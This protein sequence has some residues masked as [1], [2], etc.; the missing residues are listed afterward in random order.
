MP[1]RKNYDK[2]AVARLFADQ[3]GLATRS[4]L[5]GLGVP[6]STI[7]H[8]ERPGGPWRRVLRGVCATHDHA[9][10]R[11]AAGAVRAALLYAGPGSVATGFA[12]L[13]AHG[14]TAATPPIGPAAAAL[15]AAAPA[16]PGS[17]AAAAAA[18]PVPTTITIPFP[19]TAA[20]SRIPDPTAPTT[21]KVLIPS[22]RRRSSTGYVLTSRTRRMPEPVGIEGCRIAPVARAAVDACLDTRDTELIRRIVTELVHTGLCS[23]TDLRVE[24]DANQTR[25]SARMRAVLVEFADGIRTG[26]EAQCRRRLARVAAPPALWNRRVVERSTG[27]VAPLPV[28][29]WPRHGVALDLDPAPAG[30]ESAAVRRRWISGVLRMTVAQVTA[31]EVRDRWDEVWAELRT[32]LSRPPTYQLPAGYAFA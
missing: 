6:P 5:I 11:T 30:H 15:A 21:V 29:V 27:R 10:T 9:T 16:P 32:L 19:S 1:K 18:A 17:P 13:R 2:R 4:Q 26:A 25:Q 31:S 7:R 8:R 12:A 28:A 23:A 22:T 20:T 3:G 24:L 14:I